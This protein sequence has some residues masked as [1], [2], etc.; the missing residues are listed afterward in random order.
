MAWFHN[1]PIPGHP[2]EADFDCSTR[3]IP[4]K[5]A[6]AGDFDGDEQAEIAIAPAAGG[7]DGNDFWVMKFSAGTWRHLSPIAN[8]PLG[9]D[10]DCSTAGFPAKFAVAGGFDGDGSDEIAIAPAVGDSR[11]NDF[12]VMKFDV[13]TS[14]WLH[15][16]PIEG[17][18]IGADIDC[19]TIGLPANFAVAADIDRDGR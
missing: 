18:S 4:A 9:A 1:F 3:G 16:S 12:W 17:N 6:V 7:S 5:F 10:F 13:L 8:H 2:A 11:G 15:M 19:S 14:A